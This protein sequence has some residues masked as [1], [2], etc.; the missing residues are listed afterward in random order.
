MWLEDQPQAIFD[1]TAPHLDEW[2]ERPLKAF[3]IY[4]RLF[5]G[6]QYS[7]VSARQY[8]ANFRKL[9]T[10]LESRKPPQNVTTIGPDG[11]YEFLTWLE[12]RNPES[13]IAQSTD[14]PGTTTAATRRQVQ[15]ETKFR[16]IDVLNGLMDHLVAYGYR[17][18]NPMLDTA[19]AVKRGQGEGQIVFL[20]E[21][22]DKLLQRYLLEDYDVSTTLGKRNRALMLML[23]GTGITPAQAQGAWVDDFIFNDGPAEFVVLKERPDTRDRKDQHRVRLSAFCVEPIVEWLALRKEALIDG[24]N[25]HG[26]R[27]AFPSERTDGRLSNEGIYHI[28][29]TTFE[30]L[31]LDTADVGP[32]VLRYTFMRRQIKAGTFS[33]QD[34]MNMLG[35]GTTKTLLRVRKLTFK[36]D[37]VPV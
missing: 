37:T 18:S 12:G 20:E 4:I 9:V 23:L 14:E 27:L 32:R 7:D 19:R 35:L 34:L 36:G 26:E 22:Q 25:R 30:T 15:S 31:G 6:K 33:D 11:L 21:E 8:I 16:Y 13:P 3:E 28:V 10:F 29:R 24:P 17:K 1:I 2:V 5:A